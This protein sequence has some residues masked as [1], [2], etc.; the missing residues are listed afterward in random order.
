[1]AQESRNARKK[2]R[3]R[4]NLSRANRQLHAT[5]LK[6]GQTQI[7]L[8]Q[9]LT[10][11]GGRVEVQRASTETVIK[12]LQKLGWKTS[13]GTLHPLDSEERQS[14]VFELVHA[15]A[16]LQTALEVVGAEEPNQLETQE[17][18]GQ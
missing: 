4:M 1:M 15:D 16:E 10:E 12:R 9:I 13:P 2:R 5:L 6:F 3:T 17:R 11:L 18:G 8:F 7:A 14:I